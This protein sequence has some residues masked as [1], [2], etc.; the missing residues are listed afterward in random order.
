MLLRLRSTCEQH[1]IATLNHRWHIEQEFIFSRDENTV[2]GELVVH[3]SVQ[4]VVLRQGS[5]S[6]FLF[7]LTLLCSS[8]I[9][10]GSATQNAPKL[11]IFQIKK[12]KN[13]PDPSPSGEGDNPSPCPTPHFGARTP[14]TLKPWLPLAASADN[15]VS[16]IEI[17][18]SKQIIPPLPDTNHHKPVHSMLIRAAARRSIVR[19]CCRPMSFCHTADVCRNGWTTS[20]FASW[21]GIL[22]F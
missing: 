9:Q 21:W 17:M 22:V 10:R 4:N 6:S 8:Y 5:F 16:C 20:N 13:S 14:Q 1:H 2:F 11:T 18:P 7:C 19:S 12:S 15:D 3:L